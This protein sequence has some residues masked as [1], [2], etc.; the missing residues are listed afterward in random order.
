M[1]LIRKFQIVM[2][3]ALTVFIVHT[4]LDWYQWKS[5]IEELGRLPLG[6]WGYLLNLYN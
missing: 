2:T 1:T 3:I 5:C 4:V 6:L